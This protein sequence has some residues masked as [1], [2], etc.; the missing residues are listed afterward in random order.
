MRQQ[1]LETHH[2]G[3]LTLW[4]LGPCWQAENKG[5]HFKC[6]YAQEC[7]NSYDLDSTLASSGNKLE[8]DVADTISLHA[9]TSPYFQLTEKLKCIEHIDKS[10]NQLKSSP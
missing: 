6:F 1:G 8:G 7:V 10:E 4:T 3:W 2:Q 9:Q 5:K